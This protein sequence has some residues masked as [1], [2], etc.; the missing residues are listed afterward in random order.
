MGLGLGSNRV[1]SN[2]SEF[3]SAVDLPPFYK[4]LFNNKW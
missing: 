1:I 3:K 4:C 2:D